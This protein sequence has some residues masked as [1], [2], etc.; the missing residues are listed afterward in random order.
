LRK[1]KR[2]VKIDKKRKEKRKSLESKEFIVTGLNFQRH[3]N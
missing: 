1:E 2:L 3:A